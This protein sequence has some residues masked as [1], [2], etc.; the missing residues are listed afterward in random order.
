MPEKIGSSLYPPDQDPFFDRFRVYTGDVR[1]HKLPQLVMFFSLVSV[2]GLLPTAVLGSLAG[3][4]FIFFFG[5]NI[6][7]N[8]VL[9]SIRYTITNIGISVTCDG[10][11]IYDSTIDV[12]TD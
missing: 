3:D 4:L 8:L 10:I 11:V 6:S 9:N 7:H 2:S 12:F 5:S 1:G